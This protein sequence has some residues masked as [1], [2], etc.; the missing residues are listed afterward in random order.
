MLLLS[1]HPVDFFPCKKNVVIMGV[2]GDKHE[3]TI[4]LISRERQR[5]ENKEK[6]PDTNDYPAF[7]CCLQNIDNALRRLLC[8]P[9]TCV[10]QYTLICKDICALLHTKLR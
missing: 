3:K 1:S 6:E 5:K 4:K 8:K 9:M 10:G 7:V 2:G